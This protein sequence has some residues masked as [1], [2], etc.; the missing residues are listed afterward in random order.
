MRTINEIK[1]ALLQQ[2]LSISDS[3]LWEDLADTLIGKELIAYGTALIYEQERI[4]DQV[5]AP[6]LDSLDSYSSLAN[7]A[8]NLCDFICKIK[9]GLMCINYAPGS[10]AAFNIKF[11]PNN[12]V[13][14]Y[15]NY[16]SVSV[17]NHVTLY[18]G[19]HRM[20]TSC[21]GVILSS[22]TSVVYTDVSLYNVAFGETVRKVI[23]LG[24]VVRDSLT[25]KVQLDGII[26]TCSQ[27]TGF[28]SNIYVYTPYNFADGSVGVVIDRFFSY[29][30]VLSNLYFEWLEPTTQNV[31]YK[32]AIYTVAPVESLAYARKLLNTVVASYRG[33]TA[34]NVG[35]FLASDNRVLGSQYSGGV[36]YIKLRKGAS[37]DITNV[38]Q[39]VK[40]HSLDGYLTLQA[41]SDLSIV[42]GCYEKNDNDYLFVDTKQ[43]VSEYLGEEDL[44]Y[45]SNI[46][47]NKVMEGMV[48]KSMYYLLDFYV[49]VKLDNYKD[50]SCKVSLFN[51]VNDSSNALSDKVDLESCLYRY[52]DGVYW[53]KMVNSYAT[54]SAGDTYLTVTVAGDYTEDTYS[55][56]SNNV[57][58]ILI[59]IRIGYNVARSL[60]FISYTEI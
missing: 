32:D 51:S 45:T 50:N 16:E 2:I 11:V 39:S 1:T 54:V 59:P 41:S 23:K 28:D 48:N 18:Q 3:N 5:I 15:Y 25:V 56:K 31:S 44:G 12:G 47:V 57:I 8:N 6:S 30:S 7:V 53:N 21:K 17:T 35:Q 60:S 4:R 13:A 24:K 52:S 9:P 37:S 43:L 14:T 10:Y 38:Q 40:N 42:V 55:D 20:S 19:I 49:G 33:I 22:D 36:V 27:D 29:V 58:Y 26:H 34:K 46:P